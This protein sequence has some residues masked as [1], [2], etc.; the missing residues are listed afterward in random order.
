MASFFIW[1]VT[2]IFLVL[3][4]SGVFVPGLP[5]IALVFLGILF[6]SIS[7]GFSS[8]SVITVIALGVLVGLGALAD[9]AGSAVG[10]KY[11]GGGRW[12]MLGTM[13]GAIVGALAG[14][15][16]GLVLG[17]FLGALGG[18]LFEGKKMEHA[19]KAAVFSI[20]G[21][22]GSTIVQFALALVAILGFLMAVFI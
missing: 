17:V 2:I 1:I 15:V 7:T 5:G 6:Y 18:A 21:L 20:L 11:G 16:L 13:A 4:L 12:A 22:L 10:T 9:Y 8:I 3:G 14:G 19:G